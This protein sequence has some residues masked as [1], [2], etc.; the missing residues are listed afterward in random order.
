MLLGHGDAL[1]GVWR[2][3]SCAV[4]RAAATIA[5][6][7]KTAENVLHLISNQGL[8]WLG[9]WF[10]P[11]IPLI[12]NVKVGGGQPTVAK[13]RPCLQL[14]VIMYVRGWA[15]V[16]CNVPAREIFR[17][18]RWVGGDGRRAH[19]NFFAINLPPH[20][21]DCRCGRRR[22]RRAAAATVCDMREVTCAGRV[23]AGHLLRTI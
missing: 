22:W 10:S 16:T 18:S 4:K 12:N 8:V 20:K 23:V 1:S 13:S 21:A 7:F 11:L 3:S 5:F 19:R 15:V 14:I 9:L 2:G 6:Q 17:A